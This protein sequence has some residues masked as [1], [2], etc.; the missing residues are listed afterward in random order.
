M[1]H[2]KDSVILEPCSS[3]RYSNCI[4]NK[5]GACTCLR[6]TDFEGSCPFYRERGEAQDASVNSFVSLIKKRRF[7]LI[8]KYK[9]DER[10]SKICD[11]KCI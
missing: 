4:A 10:L 7:D 11:E 2:K 6:D 9:S 1:I 3:P 5:D 8:R